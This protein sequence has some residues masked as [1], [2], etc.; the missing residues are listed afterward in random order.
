MRAIFY[1][2]LM[3]LF[4]VSL[5]GCS[6]GNRGGGGKTR[7]TGACD[8]AAPNC[9]EDL[10]CEVLLSG[11]TRCVA[12]LTIR[13][14]VL[15]TTSNGPIEGALVQ[16]VDANGAVVGGSVA[17]EADGSFTLT[18]PAI[19]DVDEDGTPVEGSYT[20]RAQAAGYQEF[21]TAIR[22]ALPLDAETAAREEP[23]W[24]IENPLTTVKLIPLAGDV[25]S[26]GSISGTIQA[27]HN[28]G[29]LVVAEGGGAALIGFSDG[30]GQYTI[31]NVPAG[32]YA[33]QAYAAGVQVVPTSTTLAAGEQKAGV[34]LAE[35]NQPLSR[36]SGNVQIVNAPGGS[37][38][39]IVLAVE[40]TF[41]EAAGRG[42]VPPGLRVGDVSGAFAIEEV[43]DGRYVVLAAFENDGLVR[44]PDQT[45]GGT[46]V[47]H[48]EVPDGEMGNAVVLPE[49]FK[50]T[51]ALAVVSPGA[52]GPEEV[53]T[54]TPDLVWQDDSSED[55]YE[56]RFFDAFGNE[57]WRHEGGPVTGS[58]TVT[59][60]YA[61]PP[62][63]V[64]MFYQFRA[65]SFRERNG[66]RTAIS[67][68]E[69]LKGVFVHLG[70]ES[71]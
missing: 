11:E 36:V 55:G 51:G 28:T 71:P 3:G 6:G 41:V 70:S 9:A 19:R 8:P 38:T 44:D 23:G 26:L 63:E 14:Q 1:S 67:S 33:V 17:T 12:T 46:R 64:G 27:D 13:G 59:R 45:I 2:M 22:P 42:E 58:A 37:R 5:A 32:G 47:V 68:T 52:D 56:I 40:S 34:D 65:T 24:V 49:G 15:D 54:P 43:P 53:S 30:E 35:S 61:G 62:L 66:T 25:S 31:F 48:I 29:M 16:A 69:D 60:A 39:S 7:D 10:V 21:P 50:V 4:L 57:L 18:V 20:L